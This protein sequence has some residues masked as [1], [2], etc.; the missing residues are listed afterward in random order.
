M[1]LI[2]GVRQFHK[3]DDQLAFLCHLPRESKSHSGLAPTIFIINKVILHRF[4]KRSTWSWELRFPQIILRWQ[5]YKANLDIRDSATKPYVYRPAYLQE[6]LREV[7]E[8][9]KER[10]K[11]ISSTNDA[12]KTRY[13]K[14]KTKIWV[15]FLTL[16]KTH[17]KYMVDPVVSS[18]ILNC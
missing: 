16:N 10:E 7:G 4:V 12:D 9:E 11:T 15:L 8:G 2:V 18:A 1:I 17:L 13:H 14:H 6:R 5:L 3:K